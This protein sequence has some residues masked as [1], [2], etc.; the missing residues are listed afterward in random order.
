[1][2]INTKGKKVTSEELDKIMDDYQK[3]MMKNF[4]DWPGGRGVMIMRN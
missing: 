3:E 2:V 4:R 1:M